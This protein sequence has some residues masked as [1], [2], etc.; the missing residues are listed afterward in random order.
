MFSRTVEDLQ[1]H[2]QPIEV[3]A[4]R[5]IDSHKRGLY[6]WMSGIVAESRF[7]IR[8]LVLFRVYRSLYFLVFLLVYSV[9]FC[10]RNLK[11]EVQLR[12]PGDSYL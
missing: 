1:H 8:Y 9:D 12:T 7:A 4:V 5:N 3:N 10:L 6:S 11:P 2:A